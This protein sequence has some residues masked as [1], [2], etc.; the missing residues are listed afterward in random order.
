MKTLD[1]KQYP[2]LLKIMNLQGPFRST[3]ILHQSVRSLPVSGLLHISQCF[4]CQ[5]FSIHWHV[6]LIECD[7]C[8][9]GRSKWRKHE[10]ID[11][12]TCNSLGHYERNLVQI[13]LSLNLHPYDLT[14]ALWLEFWSLWFNCKEKNT[15]KISSWI[16]PMYKM[17]LSI[18]THL[19]S[20]E[21][22]FRSPYFIWSGEKRFSSS[23]NLQSWY[24][25]KCTIYM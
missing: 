17:S 12:N 7:E 16:V 11:I 3:P 14:V 15:I 22:Y 21:S 13:L 20:S 9:L 6:Y 5:V 24:T 18:N 4:S 10:D 25:C 23:L 2:H 1:T 8:R 19:L